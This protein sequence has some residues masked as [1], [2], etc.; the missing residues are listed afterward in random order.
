MLTIIAAT[1]AS[2]TSCAPDEKLTAFLELERRSG[3][4]R[5]S[6][7]VMGRAFD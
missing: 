6:L 3:P 4:E 5:Q 2:D 1:A 7:H